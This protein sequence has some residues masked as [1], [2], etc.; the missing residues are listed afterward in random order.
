MQKMKDENSTECDKTLSIQELVK[1]V[2]DRPLGG[3]K[4]P[5]MHTQQVQAYQMFTAQIFHEILLALKDDRKVRV[6]NFGTFSLR[7]MQSHVRNPKTGDVVEA[8]DRKRLSFTPSKKKTI[9]VLN[10]HED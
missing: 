6:Q 1:E 9:S 10:D 3:R 8:K 5:R 4:S 7:K 2:M